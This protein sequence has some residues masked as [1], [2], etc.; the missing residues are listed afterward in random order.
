[1]NRE[2]EAQQRPQWQP[3]VIPIQLVDVPV[4]RGGSDLQTGVTERGGRVQF[5]S[6]EAGERAA[7]R[8]GGRTAPQ[9]GQAAAA[10]E[11]AA[12]RGGGGGRT[13]PQ[14]GQAASAA[15]AALP[16]R[17]PVTIPIRVETSRGKVGAAP[18]SQ[19]PAERSDADG[20][21]GARGGGG[22]GE[23]SGGDESRSRSRA[24]GEGAEPEGRGGGGGQGDQSGGDERRSR[25]REG[26]EPEGRGGGH[27]PQRGSLLESLKRLS[28]QG[29]PRSGQG[30]GPDPFMEFF[31]GDEHFQEFERVFETV[32]NNRR[33]DP[34]PLRRQGSWSRDARPR[35]RSHR[36]QDEDENDD[37]EDEDGGG[38]NVLHID[39]TFLDF[40]DNDEDFLEFERELEKVR[41]NRRRSRLLGSLTRRPPSRDIFSDVQAFCQRSL[42]G[43]G[44]GGRGGG[45]R[46][47]SRTPSTSPKVE[48]RLSAARRAD[49]E[50]W[51]SA[52]E[53]GVVLDKLKRNSRLFSEQA[54]AAAG[55]GGGGGG[56]GSWGAGGRSAAAQDP[57]SPSPSPALVSSSSSGG[58]GVAG[59]SPPSL[60]RRGAAGHADRCPCLTGELRRL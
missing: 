22:Q 44:G 40:F 18:T 16:P 38:L 28:G 53:W 9:V 14:V 41:S 37:D 26:A 36:D 11:R 52:E 5:D 51:N 60:G 45:G 32:H 20:S 47:R 35:R 10:G 46:G 27:N 56:G 55:G 17:G 23:Q 58:G 25:S 24:V 42:G 1:M 15:A 4:S 31:S 33:D 29:R 54:T 43:G 59:P 21:Q 6:A 50:L 30:R 39:E 7:G 19:R 3:F 57:T 8:G 34:D 48:R 2:R 12:G 49:S 13:A